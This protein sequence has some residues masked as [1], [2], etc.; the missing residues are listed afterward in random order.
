MA[1]ANDDGAFTGGANKA[2]PTALFRS[3]PDSAA[4]RHLIA[5]IAFLAIGALF[6][7]FASVKLAFPTVF[8]QAAFAGYARLRPMALNLLVHGFGFLLITSISYYLLPRLTGTRLPFESI[9][10]ANLFVAAGAVAVGVVLVGAGVNTGN[11]LAEFPLWLD[12]I[13][14]LSTLVPAV[15]VTMA[16]IKRRENTIYPSLAFLAAAQLI[17]PWLYLVGNLWRLAGVGMQLQNTFMV[18]GLVTVVLPA[19]A[20]AGIYYLVPKDADRPLYSRQLA[21]AGFWTLLFTGLASGQ[22]RFAGGPSPDWLDTVGAVLSL[23]LLVTALTVAAN[24]WYTIEGAWEK[25]QGSPAL[26]LTVAGVAMHLAVTILLAVQGFRAVAAIVGLTIWY[27]ALLIATMLGSMTLLAAGFA[28]HAYP[29]MSGRDVYSGSAADRH[30][31]LT[32]WGI[33]LASA[34]GVLTSLVIGMTWTSN[35]VSGA[36]TNFGD[37]FITSMGGVRTLLTL[38]T[39]PMLVGVLGALMFALNFSR[40]VTTGGITTSEVLTEPENE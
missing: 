5:A 21:M 24:V 34:A 7:L 30:L 40:T 1:A 9:A 3:A 31:K 13:F 26:R 27:D 10:N 38:N 4:Q 33:G 35:V 8:D 17:Y 14:F 36:A 16:I 23:G 20:I 39:L 6:V 37:G 15:V 2:A 25:V 32:L 11:D 19:G 22:T 18:G 29:R 28:Y 12:V